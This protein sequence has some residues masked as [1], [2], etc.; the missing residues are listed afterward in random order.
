MVGGQMVRG[1][2]LPAFINNGGYHLTNIAVYADGMI[3]CWEMVDIEGF[4]KKL[5]SRWV[6]TSLPEDAEVS[7]SGVTAFTAKN[8]LFRVPESEF[9]KEVID[10]I[11]E[12]ND[13]PTSAMK[14]IRAKQLYWSE[15]TEENSRLMLEAF[16]NVPHHKKKHALTERDKK[17][18][19]EQGVKTHST[20]WELDESGSANS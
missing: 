4:I 20:V 17:Y 13:R 2:L 3:Y 16:E 6:V 14:F 8:I 1:Q 18:L 10:V 15:P 7:V 19:K 12:L 9:L 11:E 5:N